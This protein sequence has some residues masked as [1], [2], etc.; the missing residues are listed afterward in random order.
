MPIDISCPRPGV[1]KARMAF[2][3][4]VA[5]LLAQA[6]AASA[7]DL[8]GLWPLTASGPLLKEQRAIGAFSAL[9]LDTA[10][11]VS[12][13]LGAEDA[14]E[15][16]AEGNVVPL[17]DAQVVGRTLVV[18]DSGAYRK[19][20]AVV[21]VTA[22]RIDAI[23]VAGATAVSADGLRG[24]ALALSLG[25]SSALRLSDLAV[26]RLSVT[27][28][29]ASALKASGTADSLNATLGGA[30][31]LQASGL[32]ARAVSVEGGGSSQALV[33]AL[34]SLSGALAGAAGLGHYGAAAAAV[35]TSGAARVRALGAAPPP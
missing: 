6:P 32:A 17:I 2:L 27:M 18:S 22:R 9:K 1:R 35:Q 30:S 8:G 4:S 10:A 28:G 20:G 11:R 24:T 12:V 14:V 3:A 25:G 21:R 29:G 13:R 5:L 16:E 31:A 15:V 33:W 34:E 23:S 26:Q 7:F 19:S